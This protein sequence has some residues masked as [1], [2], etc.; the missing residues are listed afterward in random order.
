MVVVVIHIMT[1]SYRSFEQGST[2]R[3]PV[4]G[5]TDLNDLEVKNSDV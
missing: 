4:G 2:H 1:C 5:M 3:V